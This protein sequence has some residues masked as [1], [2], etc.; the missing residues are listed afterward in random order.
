MMDKAEKRM[1]EVRAFAIAYSSVKHL[2]ETEES[3]IEFWK[4][5][6]ENFIKEQDVPFPEVLNTEYYDNNIEEHE[7][8]I[9]ALKKILETIYK[10]M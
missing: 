4:E 8:A 6:K 3:E 7:V 1:N 5:S 9:T 2:I 10:L